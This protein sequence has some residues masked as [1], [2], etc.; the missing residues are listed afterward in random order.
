V[1]EVA[2]LGIPVS[3][4]KHRGPPMR[5]TRLYKA[6]IFL[7]FFRLP[8]W[9]DKKLCGDTLADQHCELIVLNTKR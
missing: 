7:G 1:E 6:L 8:A 5:P 2:D 9:P 3:N 4:F